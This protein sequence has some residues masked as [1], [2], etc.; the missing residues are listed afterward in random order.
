MRHIAFTLVLF[1]CASSHASPTTAPAPGKSAVA[2]P[3][4][5]AQDSA[6]MK[7]IEKA[8]VTAAETTK[9]AQTI[10]E[11]CAALP[12]LRAALSE[13]E[14]V[15]APKGFER[16]FGQQRE[17]LPMLLEYMQDHRCGDASAE[18]GPDDIGRGIAS[19]RTDFV[20]LQQI[21][22]KR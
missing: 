22:A 4:R 7:A 17:G 1:A 11:A 3:K 16:E 8:F 9:S 2:Q 21:G 18:S 19:T 12:P 13:L 6:R 14:W 10:K 15:A 5:S 20:K